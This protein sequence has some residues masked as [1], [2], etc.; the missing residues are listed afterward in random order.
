MKKVRKIR[1][2]KTI[3]FYIHVPLV[4]REVN[5][6]P[7]NMSE[8]SAGS[9]SD[10]GI[11][12]ANEVRGAN[13]RWWLRMQPDRNR[14]TDRP[15]SSRTGWKNAA[16][17]YHS[18]GAISPEAAPRENGPRRA[19]VKVGSRA[20]KSRTPRI[21]DPVGNDQM[22]NLK[23]PRRSASERGSLTPPPF[24]SFHIGKVVPTPGP[25]RRG[26]LPRGI[27][28]PMV[29]NSG[30]PINPMSAILISEAPWEHWQRGSCGCARQ[31]AKRVANNTTPLS[32]T[33]I[34]D[35]SNLTLPEYHWHKIK[36]TGGYEPLGTV[37]D[38]GC[39]FA[40]TAGGTSAT[41]SVRPVREA[42]I[43]RAIGGNLCGWNPW[44]LE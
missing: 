20:P 12:F 8:P 40:A 32:L 24:P 15:C 18:K 41:R 14:Q 27:N 22:A 30:F 13:R 37:G 36:F 16:D 39:S 17:L 4:D 25:D 6:H 31:S 42:L 33:A 44:R 5:K 29:C 10:C 23:A 19:K 21:Q 9:T 3:V 43:S 26:R 1:K 2:C 35:S 34:G 28:I 7:G 11:Y 38:R